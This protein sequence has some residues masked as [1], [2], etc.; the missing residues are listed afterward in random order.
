[1]S[2]LGALLLRR[3]TVESTKKM[4]LAMK[5]VSSTRMRKAHRLFESTVRAKERL[6]GILQGMRAPEEVCPP[7]Y[8]TPGG[9]EVW[10]VMGADKGLCG[11]FHANIIRFV[12]KECATLKKQPILYVWGSKTAQGLKKAGVKVSL[13]RPRERLSA[14][15]A[16]DHMIKDL[17][18]LRAKQTDLGARIRFRVIIPRFKSALLQEVVA[19]CLYQEM[20]PFLDQNSTKRFDLKGVGPYVDSDEK[21]MTVFSDAQ[22]AN[23][24]G[25]QH[26]AARIEKLEVSR[27]LEKHLENKNDDATKK[28]Q[29]RSDVKAVQVPETYLIEPTAVSF[30]RHFL[31]T[32]VG[33]VLQGFWVESMLSEEAARM[34]AMD[35]ANRNSEDI[36][37]EITLLYNRTRQAMITKE[38]IEVISGASA[39]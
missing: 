2:G 32:Y 27:G 38:L 36:L 6:A 22:K 14:L 28:A 5:A 16:Y 23:V 11:S 37:K 10:C 12:V 9:A 39:L 35:S 26:K 8:A 34:A 18:M 33:F 24:T 4:M 19:V 30:F 20:T 3:A 25:N 21:K 13:S 7:W 1:M 31:L 15:K 29:V 17:E